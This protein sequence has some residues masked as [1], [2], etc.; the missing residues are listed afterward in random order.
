MLWIL[1]KKVNV[2]SDYVMNAYTDYG[3][4]DDGDM[5]ELGGVYWEA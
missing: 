3:E 5:D 1:L 4:M 2:P